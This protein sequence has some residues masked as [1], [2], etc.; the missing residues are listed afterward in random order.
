MGEEK[1]APV[2]YSYIELDSVVRMPV[3]IMI[4]IFA[5]R[6]AFPIVNCRLRLPSPS[7]I[8]KIDRHAVG[9]RS[10]GQQVG[11][12]HLIESDQRVMN[13]PSPLRRP[14]PVNKIALRRF[15]IPVPL[16]S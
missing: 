14:V 13:L 12:H 5:A 9:G 11:D 1:R 4:S 8:V 16:N 6:P 15:A 10:H 7:G 2:P 3:A